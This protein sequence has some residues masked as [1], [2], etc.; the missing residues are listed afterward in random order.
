MNAGLKSTWPVA[1]DVP[2][3]PLP[4]A[5]GPQTQDRVEGTA[6]M[7]VVRMKVQ[8]EACTCLQQWP[9][10]C[11]LLR[12]NTHCLQML[13]ANQLLL[14]L[15]QLQQPGRC[16]SARLVSCATACYKFVNHCRTA[17]VHICTASSSA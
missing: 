12:F 11:T 9:V 10:V 5:A 7:E 15:Q 16:T 8:G 4:A 17:D 3:G 1:E 13:A 14:L 6:V 2:S